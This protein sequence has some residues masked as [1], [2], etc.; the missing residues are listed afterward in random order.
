MAVSVLTATAQQS[1]SQSLLNDLCTHDSLDFINLTT[2]V[3]TRLF[4]DRED[5]NER[6]SNPSRNYSSAAA[7]FY[8][9]AVY[10]GY[11]LL[12]TISLNR[13]DNNLF[14]QSYQWL[15]DYANSYNLL[16][17]IRQH[18]IFSNPEHVHYN[19]ASLP[20]PPK[21]YRAYVDPI[22]TNI[23]LEEINVDTGDTPL[24]ITADINYKKWLHSFDASLQFSQAYISPNWY[25]GGNNNLNMIGQARYHVKLNPEFYPK[26]LF[27][28]TVQYKLALNSAP[29][30]SIHS[31]NIS[32]DIFQVN[33]TFGLKAA[34]RWYYSANLMFKTQLFKSYPTN[35]RSLKSA[36]M[37]PG[38]LNL[39]L[40]MT[41]NYES[42]K[43]N[44][45]FGAS[46]SPLSWNLKTCI[47]NELDPTAYGIDAGH[48]SINKFGSS[49]EL[50]FNWKI[51]YNISYSSRLF[52]FTDYD[53]FQGDWEHTI[54]FNINK[55]LSTRFYLHMRYDT[56]TPRPADSEKWHKFQLKE[57]FSFGFAY[58]F[59][60]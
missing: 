17:T 38:E 54:D 29:D 53:K 6:I 40:G 15:D 12:D 22:S 18:Y 36:L 55:F 14:A 33:S 19:M 50:N 46:I 20:E 59:G 49:A 57:I 8:A 24:N 34:K 47:N 37:S 9:P 56:T 21:A 13:T 31:I 43:K 3:D 30:D 44:F 23:V 35:S 28:T 52:A 48:K 60:V 25:Q 4:I 41:Y 11:Q 27:E 2:P 45:T 16:N 5:F 1:F 10:D 51:A 32:E 7:S 26:V 58:H 42:P 39:G